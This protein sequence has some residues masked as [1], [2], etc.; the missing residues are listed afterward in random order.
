VSKEIFVNADAR[1]TRIAVRE[2]GQLVE[3]HI[4]REERVVGSIYKGRVDNV[5]PGMDAAF[6]EIG[7]D[8]NAFLYAGDIVPGSAEDAP[9]KGGGKGK[10]ADKDDEDDGGPEHDRRGRRVRPSGNIRDIV[11]RGQEILVQVVKGPRGTKGSRVSTRISLPGRYL[12]FMPDEASV[13]VSRKI[14]D[15]KERDR[16]KRIVEGIRKPGYGLIVR[17]EAEDKTERELRQDLDFLERTW[18]DIRTKAA[19]TPAPNLVYADLTLLFR[20]L[21]DAFGQ[22]VDRLV[23]D[24]AGDYRQAHELLDFFGPGLKDRVE[25]YDG[26]KPIFEH[27]G[28][29]QEIERLLKRRVWLKS[30]GYLIIDQAEALVA[31]DVNSGKFTGSTTGLSDTIVQTNLEAVQEIARQLRLRDLGGIIVLD[32]IDMGNAADRKK[33]EQAFE[34][35]LKKDKSR[36]KFSHLSPLGLIEMTRKRTGETV[37]EQM[38]EPCPYCN[39]QGKLPSPESIAIEVA[40]DLRRLART[41]S[42][43]AFLVTC[44]PQ[45]AAYLVGE[46]GEDI[47]MLEHLLQRAVYVRVSDELHQEKYE[48]QGGKM[49]DL[50]RKHLNLRRGQVVEVEVIRNPLASPPA[51]TGFTDSGYVV[52]M[53]QGAKHVG[54]VVRARLV[55]VGR[56]VAQAEVLGRGSGGGGS[57][58]P[59]PPEPSLRPVDPASERRPRRGGG[60]GSGGGDN[61]GSSGPADR[62]ARP[63]RTEK[64]ADGGGDKGDNKPRR[65]RRG[66]GGGRERPRESQPA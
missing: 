7:L 21:R 63:E 66:G 3:L 37:N 41:Q 52:E 45:V 5:L 35:A 17:T 40:R 22:D 57:S 43:E 31:I 20:I 64:P 47:E 49:D 38:D 27:F 46:E 13:G 28:I 33:V 42:A 44:H 59:L 24:S 26:E 19:T 65:P 56:S 14:D 11:K 36:C 10:G 23:L 39:G 18:A 9:G 32:L 15:P 6:V 61:S 51:A 4:E 54:Q 30:G 16:L 1:E 12:V 58:I 53:E 60:G 25:L 50:D 2:D 34:A 8:R 29:E 55:K 62:P 48:I